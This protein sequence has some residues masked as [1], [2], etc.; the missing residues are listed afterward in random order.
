MN[1]LNENYFLIAVPFRPGSSVCLTGVPVH[2]SALFFEKNTK[3]LECDSL[4]MPA[5]HLSLHV[6]TRVVDCI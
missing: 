3:F 5:V 1:G 2:C 4:G 6:T